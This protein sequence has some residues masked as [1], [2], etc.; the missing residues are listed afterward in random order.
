MKNNH[1][2]SWFGAGFLLNFALPIADP[3][4]ITTTD[5]LLAN[6][7]VAI[8]FG[9]LGLMIAFFFRKKPQSDLRYPAITIASIVAV[10]VFKLIRLDIFSVLAACAYIWS[11]RSTP[12]TNFEK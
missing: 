6:G 9:L 11:L 1:Y 3:T 7:L 8:P 2:L 5:V 12:I 10:F 4:I